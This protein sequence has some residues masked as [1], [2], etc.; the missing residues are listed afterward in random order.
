MY[1][2]GTPAGN[3]QLL[4][5]D[6]IAVLA[7]LLIWDI[8][9][10]LPSDLPR[11]SVSTTAPA[12][13]VVAAWLPADSW[14]GASEGHSSLACL[15]TLLLSLWCVSRWPGAGAPGGMSLQSCNV[16]N[17]PAKQVHLALSRLTAA[18]DPT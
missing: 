7:A 10:K 4:D 3:L 16:L 14:M 8:L 2:Q 6:R 15:L 11:P 1:F 18:G 17:A 12:H 9:Q 13:S 5:G